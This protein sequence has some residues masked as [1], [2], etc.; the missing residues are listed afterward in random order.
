M[1]EKNVEFISGNEKIKLLRKQLKMT[2]QEF[3]DSHFTRGYLGLLENGKRNI[4]LQV[5]KFIGK[6][7]MEKAKLQEIE[8]E[9]EDDYFSRSI[10]EDA[11]KYC[12]KQ[13]KNDLSLEELA[14]IMDIA[15]T[16]SLNTIEAMVFKTI[17]DIYFKENKYLEAYKNYFYS[18]N[19]L[20]RDSLNPEICYVYNRLGYCK[21]L[22]LDY[23]EA[24]V[25]YN[26]A[27]YYAKVFN[28]E[29][30]SLCASYNL[31]LCYKYISKFQES[32]EIIDNF[33]AVANNEGNFLYYIN[34][35]ILKANSYE[36][37]EDFNKA[38]SILDN[39]I[40]L[41][42]ER[43]EDESNKLLGLIY[44][45]LGILYT[46]KD[47]LSKALDYYNLSQQIR[48]KIDK[49][50]VA[51]TLI[52]KANIYI[53]KNLHEEAIMIIELGIERAKEHNDYEYIFKGYELL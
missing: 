10:E 6:K 24:I 31:A 2:Q 19:I 38:I 47:D 44:N 3:Q 12:E 30:I 51:R 16:Y 33:I 40:G 1:L 13:L 41:M 4:T 9:L 43:H 29:N 8:L 46:K 18:M 52:E 50:K 15:K 39:L 7:C 22:L 23:E 34:A 14:I 36:E 53:K 21:F 27:I 35:N 37:M 11:K 25:Y 32:I 42:K 26:N 28:E 20:E 48:M 17:G 45:N 49:K 5:S